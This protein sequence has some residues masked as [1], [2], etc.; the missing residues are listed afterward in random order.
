MR[1]EEEPRKIDAAQMVPGF[2]Y[3]RADIE[4]DR[5][6]MVCENVNGDDIIIMFCLSF[7]SPRVWFSRCTQGPKFKRVNTI[8]ILGDD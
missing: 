6:Y 1:F 5:R 2:I 7:C 4:S 8:I 3:E